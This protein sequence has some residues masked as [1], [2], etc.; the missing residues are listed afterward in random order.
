MVKIEVG[1]KYRMKDGGWAII[2]YDREN[3][4]NWNY[5]YVSYRNTLRP[6][7]GSP[8]TFNEEG[9]ASRGHG[10]WD[11]VERYRNKK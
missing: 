6:E 1:K 9:K 8:L 3:G 2:D 7:Q 10:N 5:R 11:I 4:L